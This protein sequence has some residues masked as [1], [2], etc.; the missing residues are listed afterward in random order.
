MAAM[1]TGRAGTL[2]V[3]LRTNDPFP[4]FFKIEI[5]LDP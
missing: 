4:L 3:E 2:I 1:M 5:V